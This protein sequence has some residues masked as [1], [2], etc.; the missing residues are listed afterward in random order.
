[1][2]NQLTKMP[3]D[4]YSREVVGGSLSGPG[5][6]SGFFILKEGAMNEGKK[7]DA[8][9]IIDQYFN[10]ERLIARLDAINSATLDSDCGTDEA[11]RSILE[12]ELAKTLDGLE[13]LKRD[14]EENFSIFEY[15]EEKRRKFKVEAELN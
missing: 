1:M 11:W 8:H 3:E 4:T 13:L 12:D 14:I 5:K 2:K 15:I 10:L 6:S 7:I 9:P